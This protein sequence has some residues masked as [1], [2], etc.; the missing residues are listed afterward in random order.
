MERFNNFLYYFLLVGIFGFL[1]YFLH[2]RFLLILLLIFILFPLISAALSKLASRRITLKLLPKALWADK[3]SQAQVE[4]VFKNPTFIPFVSC[5][6]EFCTEN[7]YYPNTQKNTMYLCIPALGEYRTALPVTPVKNGIVTVK[8]QGIFVR[9]LLN[10][11]EFKVPCDAACC[12]YVTPRITQDGVKLASSELY[13]EDSLVLAKNINGTQPD[14]IRDY[15][16]GDKLRNIHWKLSTKYDS[17]LVKE[18]SDNNEEMAI[19]LAE[20]YLPAIDSIID[21]VYS[22]G[23]ALSKAGHQYTLC[24]AP[25]G[26]EQLTKL[27]ITDGESLFDGIEKLYLACPSDSDTTS[28]LAL[29]RE[30]AGSGIIYIHG[31]GRDKA[32]TDIL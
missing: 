17:L 18:Y 7:K 10:M 13:S 29:R 22:I 31:G 2:S 30:Y 15:I 19:L 1:M 25:A 8:T 24:F 26:S 11:F 28:M 4:L 21:T 5:R 12:F 27:Y 3:D 16:P 14:G 32:V 23:T 9:D 20:L 6:I